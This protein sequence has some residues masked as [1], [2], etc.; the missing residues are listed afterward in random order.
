LGAYDV[1]LKLLESR[2][3]SRARLAELLQNRGFGSVEVQA[4]LDKLTRLGYLDDERH[5]LAAACGWLNE[6]RSRADVLQ[7]LED[8]GLPAGMAS[9]VMA[10]AIEDVGYRELHAASVLLAKKG[11][12]LGPKAARF[13]AGRGFPEDLCERVAGVAWDG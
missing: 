10:K 11:L 7:R 2:G 1:G 5:A 3:R 6:H 13:L 9:R 12:P 8:L 4:A